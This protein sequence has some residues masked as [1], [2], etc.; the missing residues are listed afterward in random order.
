MG[1]LQSGNHLLFVSLLEATTPIS[2]TT[3]ETRV[4]KSAYG[5]SIL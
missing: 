4:E 2:G 3:F 1:G 5:M